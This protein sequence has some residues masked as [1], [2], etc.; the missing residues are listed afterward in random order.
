[1][2]LSFSHKASINYLILI[3]NKIKYLRIHNISI[4]INFYQ[5]LFIN[6]CVRKNFLK[7]SEGQT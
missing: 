4:H 6:Q 7:F 1:M 5:N 3:L 2:F